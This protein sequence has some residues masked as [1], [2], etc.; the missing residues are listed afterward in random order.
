M[1]W[2]TTTPLISNLRLGEVNVFPSKFFTLYSRFKLWILSLV[3]RGGRRRI[4]LPPNWSPTSGQDRNGKKIVCWERIVIP[5]CCLEA[6]RNVL[7]CETSKAD[8]SDAIIYF[9]LADMSHSSVPLQ[10]RIFFYVA[11][12]K[13]WNEDMKHPSQDWVMAW[14]TRISKESGATDFQWYPE[15]FLIIMGAFRG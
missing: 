2:P 9:C 3:S 4:W 11:L 15:K 5:W 14:K 1:K 12:C 7:A 6:L 10:G 8:D 13:R